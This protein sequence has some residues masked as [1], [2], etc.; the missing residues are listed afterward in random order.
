MGEPAPTEQDGT[1][2]TTPVDDKNRRYR[3]AAEYNMLLLHQKQ[4]R[5]PF[6]V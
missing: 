1:V 2:A 4:E 6:Y 5:G 3:Q